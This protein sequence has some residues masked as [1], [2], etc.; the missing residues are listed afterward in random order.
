MET[1]IGRNNPNY[2]PKDEYFTP[3][4]LFD[5]LQVIFDLDVAAPEGGA[6]HV[7]TLHHY[8]KKEDGLKQKWFGNVWMNPPFSESK[9]WVL[10]FMDHKNGIALLPT[11]KAKWFEQIWA[12]AEGIALLSNQLKFEFEGKENKGIFMPCMLF[13]YGELNVKAL[14]DSGLS[15]VR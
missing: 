10:K 3:S 13:A 5:S 6:P 7:P 1:L 4:H 12:E 2:K 11:S 8:T 9:L 15:R 14:R